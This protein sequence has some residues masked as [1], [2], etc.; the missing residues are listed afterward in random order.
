MGIPREPFGKAQGYS[1]ERSR[2][3]R[4]RDYT[5]APQMTKA[6]LLGLIHD[7]TKRKTTYRIAQKNADFLKFVSGQMKL[8]GINSWIYKEG[9]LRNVWI[10][11]FSSKFLDGTKI[12]NKQDKID[13]LRG[14]FDAE[15]G[16]AKLPSVRFYLY[17]CQKNKQELVQLKSYLEN[18]GISC[19]VIHNPSVM[20]DPDFWRFYVA[21]HSHAKFARTIGSLHPDKWPLLRMKI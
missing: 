21:T 13:Y 11:E 15:G 19:G 6:Y 9:K 5:R 3:G 10:L 7:A 16:I 14:Y 18:L 8:L 4:R 17:Y 20:R 2:V 12:V 1:Y